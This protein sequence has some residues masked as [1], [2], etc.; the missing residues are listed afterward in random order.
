MLMV[1]LLEREVK[2]IK[3]PVPTLVVVEEQATSVHL[4]SI[5]LCERMPKLS[6]KQHFDL[7]TT[8]R[9][10]TSDVEVVEMSITGTLL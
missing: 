2:V 7:A 3:A 8:T 9:T 1:P 6:P 10:I 5:P 4:A